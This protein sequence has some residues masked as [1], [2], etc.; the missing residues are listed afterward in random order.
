MGNRDDE[1]DYLFKGRYR[2]RPYYKKQINTG[3]TSNS[4]GYNSDQA[5]FLFSFDPDPIF[6]FFFVNEVLLLMLIL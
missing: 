6:F 4:K 5:P 3:I 2:Y 1:Y